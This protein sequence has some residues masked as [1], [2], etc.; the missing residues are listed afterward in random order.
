MIRRRP[1]LLGAAAAAGT[2]GPSAWKR[3]SAAVAAPER[4]IWARNQAGEEVA[5]AY[6]TGD[7]YKPQAIAGLRRLLRDLRE[8]V[9]GPL[10]PMLVDML[11]VVQERWG[12][13][14]PLLVGSGYRTLKTNRSLEG[15]AP[16]SFHLRGWAA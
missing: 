8:E 14:Q 6:R 9:E 16:A 2:A 15:A 4:W 5:A 11:S 10:P 1:F 12:Y 3:A 7:A 13:A